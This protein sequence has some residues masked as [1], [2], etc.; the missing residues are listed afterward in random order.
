[1]KKIISIFI[2]VTFLLTGIV[3][4]ANEELNLVGEGALLLDANNGQVLFEKNANKKLY[5]ASTTKIMTAILAIELGELDDLINVDK[6]VVDLTEGSHIALDIGEQL[7]LKDMLHALLIESANDSALAIAKYISGDINSF[8]ELMNKKALELGAKNTNFTNPNGLHDDNHYSTA[9]DLGIITKYAMNNKTFADIVKQYSYTIGPTNKKNESRYLK[10]S[11]KLLFSDEKIRINDKEVDIK[12]PGV[13]GVKTGYTSMAKS[14][15]VSSFKNGDQSLIA[16]VLNSEGNDVFVDTHKLFNYGVNNYKPYKLAFK[17]QFIKNVK[18]DK[19]VQPFTAA[20]IKNDVFYNLTNGI[21]NKIE[22]KVVEK[23]N[24]KAPIKKGDTLGKVQF[25]L[26]SKVLKEV[27]IIST[28]D[29]EKDPSS[30]WYKKILSKWYLV[31]FFLW[32]IMRIHIVRKRKKLKELRRKRQ[33]RYKK[34]HKK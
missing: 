8:V 34:Y 28:M 20:V 3:S 4:F 24:L 13:N 1:M 12:Y 10:S 14:C 17:N 33:L 19:A 2:L 30:I 29:I 5:P 7:S 16:V 26:E 23:D 27:D 11:N 9:Y 32:F 22:T 31:V 6:E 25:L 18:I 21:E 15:L